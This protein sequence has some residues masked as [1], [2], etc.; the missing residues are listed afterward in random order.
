MSG[1][2]AHKSFY[3]Y[4]YF[5][6]YNFGVV[7][8]YSFLLSS[9]FHEQNDWIINSLLVLAAVGFG[10]QENDFYFTMGVQYNCFL[11]YL[12]HKLHV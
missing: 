5:F 3:F 6:V 8:I 11:C 10:S 4:F 2:V 7:G 1:N 9:P 12:W